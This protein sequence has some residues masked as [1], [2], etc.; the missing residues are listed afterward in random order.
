MRIRHI[1]SK[2]ILASLL[3][4]LPLVIWSLVAR[5]TSFWEHRREVMLF[6]AALTLLVVGLA[7]YL[8][9]RLSRPVLVLAET[10]R[11]FGE[12]KLDARSQIRTGD[13]L[14]FLGD[15]FNEMADA[16]ESHDSELRAALDVQRRQSRQ[17]EALYSM[18]EGVVVTVSLTDKLQVIARGLAELIRAKRCIILL[19]KGNSVVGTTGWGIQHRDVLESYTLSLADLD[20][21]LLQ[22]VKELKPI[23]VT[24]VE[25][26]SWPA[27]NLPPEAAV[28]N[29][30]IIP[31]A[32][33]GRFVGA[34]VIDNPGEYSTF[35]A[36]SIEATRNLAELAAVAI[37]NAQLFEREKNIAEVL[38][39][40]LLPWIPREV[41]KLLLST[42]Y[43][44]ALDFAEVGGDFYDYIQL[45]ENRIGILIADVSGK[46]LE[47]AVYT[48]MGKYTIRAFASENPSPADVLTRANAALSRTSREWGFITMFFAVIDAETCAVTYASAGHPPCVLV[49]SDGEV[50]CIP[51]PDQQ[52]PLGIFGDITYVERSLALR[53]G[54]LLIGYTDGLIEARSN[55]DMFEIERL[56]QVAQEHRHEE[57]ETLVDSIHSSVCAFCHDRISDDM[58]VLIVKAR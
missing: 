12:G 36:E 8:G 9:N 10:V 50:S 49:R 55:G 47:A 21:E 41:R 19:R 43:Y 25:T 53:P 5:P 4:L 56:C 18:A 57:P 32:H 51:C 30:L 2:L 11:A 7:I 6:V 26:K 48:A 28:R 17:V 35:N 37:E 31:I 34:A 20:S 42:G 13:E 52:P 16:L 40:G 44:P 15:R 27:E 46:G 1:R 3:V 38:Q 23:V 29:A 54:D 14:E 58:A 45:S 33:A 22:V 39:K 24:D